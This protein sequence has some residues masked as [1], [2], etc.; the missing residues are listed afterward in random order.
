MSIFPITYPGTDRV[1]FLWSPYYTTATNSIVA[2]IQVGGY[3]LG[4][5]VS[6]D[7]NHVYV[8]NDIDGTVSVIQTCSN[9]VIDTITVGDQTASD[10][11][12]TPDGNYLYVVDG[13]DK[14][15]VIQTTTNSVIDSITV[16]SDPANVAISPDG[17]SVYVT[18]DTDR[19]ITVI[20]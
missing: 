20:Q 17:N 4:M 6:S 1:I 10:V 5:A 2:E 7:G 11:A 13:V 18:S 8:A 3:P 15:Y 9:T 16:G 12:V 14:V 19:T